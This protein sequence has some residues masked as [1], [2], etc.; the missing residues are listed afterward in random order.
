[1][2]I[3]VG[4]RV[5]QDEHTGLRWLALATKDHDGHTEAPRHTSGDRNWRVCSN[6]QTRRSPRGEFGISA[7]PGDFI[8]CNFLFPAF[9]LH[10]IEGRPLTSSKVSGIYNF[11]NVRYAAAPVGE[12]RFRPPAPP[13][14]ADTCGI[15][16][17]DVGRV[18]PAASPVW[19]TAIAPSFV[20]DYLFHRPFNGSTNVSS[21]GYTPSP[22]DPRTTEDCLFL[23]VLTPKDVFQKGGKVPVIVWIY[24]G[25]YTGGEKSSADGVSLITRSMLNGGEGLVFVAMNYRVR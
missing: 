4:R 24:G 1:M 7:A 25:G 23:D 14:P 13:P 17:G 19:E 21:Y 16:R 2:R 6:G 20:V 10:N 18:C 12:L 5:S 9:S 8:G 22:L 3:F 11:S 15:D